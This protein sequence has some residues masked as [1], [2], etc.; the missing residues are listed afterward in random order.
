MQQGWGVRWDHSVPT[1]PAALAIP[2]LQQL[3]WGFTLCFP[4]SCTARIVSQCSH[5]TA[6]PITYAAPWLCI[7]KVSLLQG[8]VLS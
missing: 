3:L 1:L 7:P 6:L 4:A 2:F 8:P 5:R